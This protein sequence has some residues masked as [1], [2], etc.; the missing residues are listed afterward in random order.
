MLSVSGCSK[1]ITISTHSWL[2]SASNIIGDIKY[3]AFGEVLTKTGN[4][5]SDYGF[6]TQYMD[7]VLSY[8]RYKYRWYSPF[9]GKWT[10][11][12]PIEE[13]GGNNINSFDVLGFEAGVMFAASLLGTKSRNSHICHG[14]FFKAG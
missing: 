6:Q 10:S 9:N 8:V 3:G 11:E 13:Q 2:D 7:P 1:N 5:Y 4:I 14:F 12:D